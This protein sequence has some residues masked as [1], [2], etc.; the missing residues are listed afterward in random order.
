MMRCS[1]S[2]IA[3]APGYYIYP[4]S[5]ALALVTSA[6]I[7]LLSTRSPPRFASVPNIHELYTL[8]LQFLKDHYTTDYDRWKRLDAWTPLG[9]CSDHIIGVIT[10]ARLTGD[11]TILPT[12]FLA[13]ISAVRSDVI[14]RGFRRDDGTQK[15]LSPDDFALCLEVKSTLNGRTIGTILRILDPDTNKGCYSVSTKICTRK[16]QAAIQGLRDHTQILMS[17]NP[18]LSYVRYKKGGEL[19]LCGECAKRTEERENEA[20]ETLW[21]QSPQLLAVDVPDWSGQIVRRQ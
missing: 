20:H 16:V 2:A 13:Y 9:F 14:V 11:L 6:R 18:F 5:T 7:I 19:R 1:T 4:Y 21:R 17:G 8:S 3:V 15:R 10:L 12:A